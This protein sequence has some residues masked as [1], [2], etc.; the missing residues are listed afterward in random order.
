MPIEEPAPQR[1]SQKELTTRI[2]AVDRLAMYGGADQ[3]VDSLREYVIDNAPRF[4]A[5]LAQC[6]RNARAQRWCLLLDAIEGELGHRAA[7]RTVATYLSSPEARKAALPVPLPLPESN[8]EA[9]EAP[10]AARVSPSLAPN[11]VT[12]NLGQNP[13]K[14][15]R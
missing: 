2:R 5:F 9:A 7:K 3:P 11:E 14:G 10:E 12:C 1:A 15:S 6:H 8:V 13:F 4:R